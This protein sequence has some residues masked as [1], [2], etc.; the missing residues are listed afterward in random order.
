MSTIKLTK[1]IESKIAPSPSIMEFLLTFLID[2]SLFFNLFKFFIEIFK[3]TQV[4]SY[5]YL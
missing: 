4:Y 3:K 5:Y 1:A 2:G